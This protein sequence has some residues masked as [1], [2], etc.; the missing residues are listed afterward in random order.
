MRAL[1][2]CV[3]VV[4]LSACGGSGGGSDKSTV[5]N[6]SIDGGDN[7]GPTPPEAPPVIPPE[8]PVVSPPV[9]PEEPDDEE[10]LPPGKITLYDLMK[11]SDQSCVAEVDK[12]LAE[13]LSAH[14]AS[15][16]PPSNTA[17]EGALQIEDES[18]VDTYTLNPPTLSGDVD[19]F[20]KMSDKMLVL[21]DESQV[22]VK[23]FKTRTGT[24]LV[25]QRE[26]CNFSIA[27]P[28]F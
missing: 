26:I 22:P 15:I 6:P 28:G 2:L 13:F 25:F 5:T 8:D 10:P 9:Q 16:L 19:G 11:P 12:P 21:D 1:I 14:S 3:A 24:Y 17:A 23:I 7:G 4:M 27:L 20:A 18:G